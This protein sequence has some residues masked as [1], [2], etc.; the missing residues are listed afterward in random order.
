MFDTAPRHFSITNVAA[1]LEGNAGLIERLIKDNKTYK[2]ISDLLR[3]NFP[4]VRRGFSERNLRLFCAK[5]GIRK[6]NQTEM[7][8]IVK[9]CVN[10][11]SLSVKTEFTTSSSNKWTKTLYQDFLN[12]IANFSTTVL[13]VRPQED[14]QA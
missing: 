3:Q 1:Y 13:R 4:E 11:V 9:D 8:P 6:M 2:E 7:D 5:H 12:R 14:R 10:K